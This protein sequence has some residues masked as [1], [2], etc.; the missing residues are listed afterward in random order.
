MKYTPLYCRHVRQVSWVSI[1]KRVLIYVFQCHVTQ[2]VTMVVIAR[3]LTHAHVHLDGLENSVRLVS[4]LLI[5]INH[6]QS[7]SVKTGK[8]WKN[9]KF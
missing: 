1:L 4:S 6:D 3:Y 9:P 2:G 8:E 7:H 5:F